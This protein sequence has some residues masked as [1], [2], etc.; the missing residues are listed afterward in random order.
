MTHK[1]LATVTCRHSYHAFFFKFSFS[2]KHT[3]KYIQHYSILW[4]QHKGTNF[5]L[6]SSRLQRKAGTGLTGSLIDISTGIQ[7]GFTSP[8]HLLVSSLATLSVLHLR[9]FK[10]VIPIHFKSSGESPEK[11][12]TMAWHDAVVISINSMNFERT[13]D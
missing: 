13:A 7:V 6:G 5:G 11:A 8:S 12:P 2:S 9:Y 4:E 10:E 3:S 1:F